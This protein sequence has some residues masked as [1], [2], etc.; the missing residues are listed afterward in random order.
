MQ[1]TIYQ[2]F[3]TTVTLPYELWFLISIYLNCVL[4]I[5]C[6]ISNN[7]V[8]PEV[9]PFQKELK[10]HAM[11]IHHWHPFPCNLI[12]NGHVAWQPLLVILSWYPVM[13]WSLCKPCEDRAPIDGCPISKWVAMT[14][15]KIMCQDSG[16]SNGRQGDMLNS[17]SRFYHKIT[18]RKLLCHWN[19][20]KYHNIIK[21]SM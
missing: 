7:Y 21:G 17:V 19:K 6:I 14:S 4:R 5:L 8:E 13:V 11:E 20:S 2:N 15:F 12:I 10:C 9:S 16:H 1:C 18:V 3:L